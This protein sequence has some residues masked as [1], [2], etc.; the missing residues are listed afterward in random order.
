M[1][2]IS[3][4]I[5]ENLINAVGWTILHSIWQGAV[6]AL[7]FAVLMF[8]LRRYSS[9][10]RYFVGTMA[11]ILV[12]GISIT[13]FINIYDTGMSA[14]EAVTP[15]GSAAPVLFGAGQTENLNQHG[16]LSSFKEY[17]T[18]HLPL[19]VTLWFLG[20]LVFVLKLAGG[21]LYNQRLK[22]YNNR[23]LDKSW[24]NHLLKLC[25]RF[26]IKKP[27]RLL[28]SALVKVPVTLGFFKPVILL[29]VG[30]VTGLPR[31]QVEALLAHEL[32]HILRKDY[33]VNIIQ[34]VIDIIYFY[35][36]GV[37]WISSYV[38]AEREN[39]CDD[40]AVSL[41]GDSLNFAR[42]LTSVEDSRI[43]KINPALA[44]A[45]KSSMLL[46]RVKRLFAPRKKGSEFTEGFV[47]ACIMAL[48]VLTLVVNAHAA[49][50]LNQD[51][52]DTAKTEE[53]ASVQ[54]LDKKEKA[55]KKEPATSE[56]AN[57]DQTIYD[58]DDEEE[59]KEQ[60]KQEE[61]SK[62]KKEEFDEFA[63]KEEE[64]KRK[65][66]RLR[67]IEREK[68]VQIREEIRRKER[69]LRTTIRE[70]L[71]KL[72]AELKK[73]EREL[74]QIERE[75]LEK[76]REELRRKERG[77]RTIDR[78]KLAKLEAE[79]AKRARDLQ[80]RHKEKTEDIK[81]EFEKQVEELQEHENELK[82]EAKKLQEINKETMEAIEEELDTET[83]ELKEQEKELEERAE[84]LEKEAVLF[85]TLKEELFKDKLIDDEEDFE[86]KLTPRGLWINGKKQTE[87]V[88]EKYKKIY[89]THTGKKLKKM[90]KFQI[91]KRK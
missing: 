12:L 29:P 61:E 23:P 6:V 3:D 21:F 55:E 40:I 16:I 48:F 28:E 25:T 20:V 53:A 38:R 33:L 8:S 60:A 70:K 87:K 62:R 75:K 30:M 42:A 4:L 24:Q 37:R 68:Y 45:G 13:T 1:N 54:V 31:A 89:E 78:E 2:L 47:G 43:E 57:P 18:H 56:E 77:L 90:K 36:P 74:R 85:N 46:S 39:C 35:H 50:G 34:S 65:E 17:F 88:F 71:E 81:Q 59:K 76:L 69:E 41:C 91:V 44:A 82:E 26:G 67:Q 14:S 51:I 63:R 10:T 58:A 9:R 84:E 64:A 86:F 15:V 7:G 52:G 73:R 49:A 32:A 5:S 72:K 80:E 22:S 27:M 83:E 11:L 19:I 79:L 66:E